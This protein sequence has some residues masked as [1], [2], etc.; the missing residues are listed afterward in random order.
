MCSKIFSFATLQTAIAIPK[1]IT[2]TLLMYEIND[3]S[4][5]ESYHCVPC[6]KEF[7][8]KDV[9]KDHKEST[10]HQVIERILEK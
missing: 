2:E 8:D 7:I 6:N 3:L 9:A 5:K 4:M 10:G 1:I